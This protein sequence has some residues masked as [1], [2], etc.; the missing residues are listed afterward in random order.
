MAKEVWARERMV[1]KVYDKNGAH[2]GTKGWHK[3][4]GVVQRVRSAAG[5]GALGVVSKAEARVEI[6]ALDGSGDTTSV[7]LSVLETVIPKPGNKVRICGWRHEHHGKLARLKAIHEAKFCVS[8]QLN[9][10]VVLGG[11]PYEWVCKE[12]ESEHQV[13]AKYT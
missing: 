6:R 13:K 8:V 11:V 3:R 12:L 1:V 4:K 9:S 2:A 10:G 7:P 5:V